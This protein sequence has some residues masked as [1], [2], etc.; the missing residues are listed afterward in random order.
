MILHYWKHLHIYWN[1]LLMLV[2]H[3]TWSCKI[4]SFFI[5]NPC[6]MKNIYIYIYIYIYILHRYIWHIY[7]KYIYIYIY[8]INNFKW[9]TTHRHTECSNLTEVRWA[10]VGHVPKSMSCHKAIVVITWRAHCFHDLYINIY[11]YI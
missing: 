1:N 6:N 4:Y 11:K 3:E 10:S 5:F 8:I 9:F 2:I 7:I